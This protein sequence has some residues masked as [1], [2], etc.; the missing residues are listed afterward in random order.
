M[1]PRILIIRMS[2]L[3]DIIHALPLLGC[4]RERYPDAHLGWLVEP[5]GAQLIEGHPLLDR[6]HVFP[7]KAWRAGKWAALRGPIRDFR[8]ELR[9]ERYD[10]A[11]D[12]QGLTKS[13]MWGLL[14]GIPRRIGFK[15]PESRELA[16]VLATER[17]EPDRDRLHVVE[18]NLCLLRGLGLE[19]P[20]AIHFPV[21]FPSEAHSHAVKILGDTATA[22]PLVVM[23]LG[24][25]WATKIWLAERF[26]A[27]ARQLVERGGVRVALAWG[28]GEQPLV[29]RALAEL[30]QPPSN[31]DEKIVPAAPGVYTLPGTTFV[32][33]GAV[34]ARARLFVGG[35]TGPTH[36]AAALGVPTV[37]MMGPLDARRNGPLGDHCLTVQHAVPRKAPWGKNHKHW[38]D[39]RTRLDLIGV[40][41]ILTPCEAFLKNG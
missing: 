34:I 6:V 39:P 28:P 26:A 14:G 15:G 32:E 38:C 40:E 37:S 21:H 12:V 3:G 23:S 11:I 35:D 24:A 17:I 33:L 1:A 9:A 13:A 10:I 22:A 29:Q 19:P 2:A 4:L 8:R 25:G 20:E 5:L 16:G 27:L 30:G 7:K 31:F 41:E 36:L 18:R